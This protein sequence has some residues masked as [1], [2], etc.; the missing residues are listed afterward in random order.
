MEVQHRSK[1][2]NFK[3]IPSYFYKKQPMILEIQ[4]NKIQPL[5]LILPYAYIKY[6]P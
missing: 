3:F 6:Y 5:F 4:N 2:E 1:F